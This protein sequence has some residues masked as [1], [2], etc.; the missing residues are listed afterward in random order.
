MNLDFF[1]KQEKA[2]KETDHEKR[3][4]LLENTK[5][6]IQRI[7]LFTSGHESLYK[8]AFNMFLDR[9]II[10][11]GPKMFRVHCSD[12]NYAAGVAPCM[13]HPHNFYVQLL[14]ETGILGFSFV[15]SLFIYLTFLSIKYLYYNYIKKKKIYTNYQ[16]CLLACL[17]ITIWP[18][19][20]N[21]NFF[22]NHLMILYALPLGFF[23]KI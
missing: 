4:K 23:K 2:K 6:E 8:T 17:L 5:P 22:N 13:T 12:P 16:I 7:V 15:F 20:P 21:G 10:G 1:I 11:H 3:Q 9:P 14:A 19:I 18:I